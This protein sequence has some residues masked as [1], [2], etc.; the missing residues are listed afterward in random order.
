[1]LYPFYVQS[2]CT[3]TTVALEIYY[4]ESESKGTGLEAYKKL[5]L[6]EDPDLTFEEYLNDAGLH[7]PFEEGYMLSLANRIHY[8]AFSK[9]YFTEPNKDDKNN[10]A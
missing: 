9:N 8:D 1:M 5:V 2:Y 7:S 3:S 4:L 10:V 6:R